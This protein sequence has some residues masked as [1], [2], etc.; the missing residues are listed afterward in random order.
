VSRTPAEEVADVSIWAM[1]LRV[2]QVEEMGYKVRRTWNGEPGLLKHEAAEVYRRQEVAREQSHRQW[3]DTLTAQRDYIAEAAQ[4]GR[5]AYR[6]V[7]GGRL[8]P[9]VHARAQVA[10]IEARAKWLRKHPPAAVGLP[11]SFAEQGEAI[12]GEPEPP[13]EWAGHWATVGGSDD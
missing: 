5:D 11:E 6:E 7:T 12:H 8:D 2:E 13:A 9:A 4:V 10:S 1:G 3:A